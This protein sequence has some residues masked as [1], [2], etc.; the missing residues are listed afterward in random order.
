MSLLVTFNKPLANTKTY[1]HLSMGS[2]DLIT[3]RTGRRAR[4]KDIQMLFNQYGITTTPIL[5][6]TEPDTDTDTE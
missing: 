4:L 2:P 3:R 6:E 1:G 5:P